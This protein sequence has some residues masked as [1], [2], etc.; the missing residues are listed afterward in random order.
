MVKN[1]NYLSKG[2]LLVSGVLVTTVLFTTAVNYCS[3]NNREKY[4]H[5]SEKGSIEDKV[6]KNTPVTLYD[7]YKEP[8]KVYPLK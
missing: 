5:D 2:M 1:N 7:N 6:N 4:L 3:Q 8:Q